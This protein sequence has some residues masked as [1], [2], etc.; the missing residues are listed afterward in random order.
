MLGAPGSGKGTIGSM[1]AGKYKIPRISTGEIFMD[2]IAKQTEL[3]K[4]AD[5]YIS[6]GQLVPDEITINILKERIALNDCKN[7]F[8]LDGFP[9]NLEQAKVL[10]KITKIDFVF[11]L[12]VPAK[13]IVKRLS[14]R[15]TCEKCKAVYN[16]ET[17]PPKKEG[18]CDK[19][20]GNLIQREDDTPDVISKRLNTH[21]EKTAPLIDYYRNEDSLI[22]INAE[23]KPEDIFKEIV[24]NIQNE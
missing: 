13:T 17:R 9:R 16:L 7:G 2:N 14:A 5:V 20:G 12:Q 6:Q 3:G 11:N 21:E 19:C 8:I 4:Q 1:L 10:E 15:R 23:Q 24:N 22:N 18:V